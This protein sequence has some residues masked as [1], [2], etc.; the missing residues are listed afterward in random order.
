MCVVGNE[1]TRAVVFADHV[2]QARRIEQVF[3]PLAVVHAGDAVAQR[4]VLIRP[5]IGGRGDT[6]QS[7]LDIVRKAGAG[8]R[9]DARDQVAVRI[10]GVRGA[11]YASVLVEVVRDV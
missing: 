2:D 10:E 6:G 5:G 9:V 8:G 3:R 7:A 11:T 1:L 4:V